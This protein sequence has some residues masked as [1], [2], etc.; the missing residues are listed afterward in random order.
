MFSTSN[1]ILSPFL[2]PLTENY[3]I[4]TPKWDTYEDNRIPIK[5]TKMVID[6]FEL[7]VKQIDILT[8]RAL[9]NSFKDSELIK[10]AK[11]LLK[12][13]HKCATFCYTTK[14][15]NYEIFNSFQNIYYSLYQNENIFKYILNIEIQKQEQ[16]KEEN[17]NIFLPFIQSLEK[18]KENITN[19]FQVYASKIFRIIDQFKDIL[20][21]E[22]EES[23]YK[24]FLIEKYSSF[25]SLEDR[26]PYIFNF[27]NKLKSQIKNENEKYKL[28]L[29]KFL[30]RA[31]PITPAPIIIQ[32]NIF[33]NLS[34][35]FSY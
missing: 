11:V 19:S 22:Q 15:L 30:A 21:P 23:L 13:I 9:N 27:Q 8:K 16:I 35:L 18:R 1:F 4:S 10:Y 28:Y 12:I 24:E 31:A 3:A 14:Y 7:L 33:Y 20:Y 26:Y 2:N 29:D 17:K 5:W 25:S 34:H 6:C 32:S